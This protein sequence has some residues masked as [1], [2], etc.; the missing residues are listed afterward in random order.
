MLAELLAD[1]I[2]QE[3]K[4]RGIKPIDVVRMTGLD[5][6]TVYNIIN[7]KKKTPEANTV[8]RICFA[9]NID[10][11]SLIG[12]FSAAFSDEQLVA[13]KLLATGIKKDQLESLVKA[14]ELLLKK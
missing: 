1:A 3:M 11:F 6:A 12:K 2:E 5:H 14:V 10:P 7:R 4:S 9:L 8:L 13:Q